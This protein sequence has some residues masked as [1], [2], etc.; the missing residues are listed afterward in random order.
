MRTTVNLEHSPPG[1]IDRGLI[2][3]LRQ[4]R[5]HDRS[6]NLID[7]DW[8]QAKSITLKLAEYVGLDIKGRNGSPIVMQAISTAASKY[9]DAGGS[10]P[11]YIRFYVFTQAMIEALA[12]ASSEY[13]VIA[14]NDASWRSQ[15]GV[16]LNE[17]L[18]EN[19]GARLTAALRNPTEDDINR[20][21]MALA[22]HVKPLIPKRLQGGFNV[23][24]Q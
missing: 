17:W 21:K 11:D 24:W 16:P 23:I 15:H 6:L 20:T 8:P 9:K 14:Q 18:A 4:H 3:L 13:L 2:A 19:P 1:A 7:F 5:H 22:N 12:V 10:K